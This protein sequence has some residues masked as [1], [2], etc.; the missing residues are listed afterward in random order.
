MFP[1]CDM[2]TFALANSAVQRRIPFIAVRS[3][4]D[5][6][7]Q[8]VPGELFDVTHE[9]GKIAYRRL[10]KSVFKKPGLVKDLIR[11][12]VN[13]EKAAKSLG[14]LLRSLLDTAFINEQ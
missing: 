5:T 10:I 1:V 4:S 3:I 6:A 11:L 7:D 14:G 12:G 9:S 8:E 2:E 13:S